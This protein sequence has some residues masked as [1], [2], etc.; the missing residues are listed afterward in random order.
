MT[1]ATASRIF[2][3]FPIVSLF[4]CVGVVAHFIAHLF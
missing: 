1:Y 4:I 2:P 3:M